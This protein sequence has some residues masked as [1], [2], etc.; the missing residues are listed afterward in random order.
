ML[1]AAILRA[2]G[3]KGGGST[4]TGGGGGKAGLYD[5]REMEADTLWSAKDVKTGTVHEVAKVDLTGLGLPIEEQVR[6]RRLVMHGKVRC[7]GTIKM[8]GEQRVLYVTAT[9]DAVDPPLEK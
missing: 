8:A 1:L 4:G 7:R 9:E 2:C 3:P 5:V 6:V